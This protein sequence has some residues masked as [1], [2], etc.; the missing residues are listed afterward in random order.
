MS[1]VGVQAALV[2][3]LAEIGVT[4]VDAQRQAADGGASGAFP[5][6][7]VGHITMT[8]FDTARETGFNFIARIHTRHRTGSMKAVKEVQD[9]IYGRLH[10]GALSVTGFHTVLVQR[11]S[12]FCEQVQD[13]A[14]HGVCEYRG[15]IEKT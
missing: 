1:S 5:V 4:A 14:F 9:A 8:P 7:E 10:R 3:A 12:S 11:E 6:V 2:G 15:L 13:G